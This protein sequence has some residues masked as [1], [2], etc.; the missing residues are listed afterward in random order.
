[1]DLERTCSGGRS[2]L[3]RNVRNLWLASVGFT[4]LSALTLPASVAV[5]QHNELPIRLPVT[6]VQS[7]P[8]TTLTIGAQTIQAIVDTGGGA[9][10]LSKEVLDSVRAVSLGDSVVST[11]AS[12]HDFE[13]RRFRVP[14]VIIGGHVFHDMVAIQ[15]LDTEASPIPNSIGRQFLSQYFVVVD[16]AGAAIT[17]LSPSM[18]NSVQTKCG[19]TR[20]PMERTEQDSQIAVSDFETQNSHIRLLWDTGATYSSLSETVAEKMQLQTIVRG[21]GSPNFYQSKMLSAAGQS[22]GPVEFVVLPLKLSGDFQGMLGRNFFEH[23]V[24]CLD[25]KRREVRVL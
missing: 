14:I 24:V 15:A 11:N 4:V 13:Y 2:P 12:G 22:F 1:M 10:K 19:L 8:V 18:K 7:N 21:P 25:Y 16:Y 20:I 9:L 3:E 6:I 17:L 23:H 5:A